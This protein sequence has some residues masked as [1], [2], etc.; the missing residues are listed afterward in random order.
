[1]S[2][3]AD[4]SQEVD[5]LVYL[6]PTSETSVNISS[7]IISIMP[8]TRLLGK[9][10]LNVESSIKS[11][12]ECTSSSVLKQLD[13]TSVPPGIKLEG[14]GVILPSSKNLIFPF[15]AANLKAVDLKII[16][17]FDNNLPYFLQ[18]NDINGSNQLNGSA[19][20][21]IPEELTW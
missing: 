16:R 12:K 20:R 4:A 1:M 11:S 17:I 10:D 8:A 18:E 5:G 21:F 14:N 19:V 15:K 13:F 7:N 9:I 2:D 3:P 6:T